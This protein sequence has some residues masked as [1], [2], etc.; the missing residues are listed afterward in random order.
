VRVTAGLVLDFLDWEWLLNGY[1]PYNLCR[2]CVAIFIWQVGFV[3]LRLGL[4]SQDWA[5]AIIGRVRS[6]V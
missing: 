1:F 2:G 5:S 3:K 6:Y 4:L